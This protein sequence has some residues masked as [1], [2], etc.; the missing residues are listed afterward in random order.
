MNAITRKKQQ[1][2]SQNH[3]VLLKLVQSSSA[4]S[5]ES[6]K[7][8]GQ[9]TSFLLYLIFKAIEGVLALTR[10]LLYRPKL[11]RQTGPGERPL[12]FHEFNHSALESQLESLRP[13]R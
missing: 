6:V 11:V 3:E 8:A 5:V 2:E 12:E 4:V 9:L 13:R 10:A 7:R 1:W